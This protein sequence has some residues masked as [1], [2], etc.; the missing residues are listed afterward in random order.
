MLAAAFLLKLTPRS[1]VDNI[2][3]FDEKEAMGGGGALMNILEKAKSPKISNP[4][5]NQTVDESDEGLEKESQVKS[6]EKSAK[7]ASKKIEAE[8]ESK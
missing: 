4:A 3:E 5:L 1:W 7:A 2:R 6:E 8:E